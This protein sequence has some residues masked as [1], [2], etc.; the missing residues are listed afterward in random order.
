MGASWDAAMGSHIGEESA[1]LG[2]DG[3]RILVVEDDWY[4]ADAMAALLEQEG[5][6]VATVAE[7][8]SLVGARP[9]D[10]AV[11]DLNLQG[12]MADDLVEKLTD[13][14]ITAVVVTAYDPTHS[15]AE[16]AFATLRKP[17]AAD[18]LL[19]TLRRAAA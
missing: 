11:V 17:V 15:V 16:R 9:I 3:R 6:P 10:L 19:D 4:I 2:L 5:G 12:E 1:R 18:T 8:S 14:S 7:A 13:N